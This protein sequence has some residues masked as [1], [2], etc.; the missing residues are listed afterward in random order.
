MLIGSGVGS[1]VDVRAIVWLVLGFHG[2]SAVSICP[3]AICMIPFDLVGNYDI[4]DP[5]NSDLFFSINQEH[6]ARY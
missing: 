5:D 1:W 6:G 3:I 4:I 2:H